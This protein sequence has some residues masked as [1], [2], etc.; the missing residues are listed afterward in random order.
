MALVY[1][2]FKYKDGFKTVRGRS[3][4]RARLHDKDLAA[5]GIQNVLFTAS[6]L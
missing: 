2:Y 6:M 5:N 1:S 4:A 3:E